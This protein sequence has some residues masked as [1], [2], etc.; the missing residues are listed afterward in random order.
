MLAAVAAVRVG[1]LQGAPSRFRPRLAQE[2]VLKPGDVVIKQGDQ[3]DAW[4]IVETGT[5]DI[6]VNGAKLASRGPGDAFG[7]LALLYNCPRA[8]TVVATTAAR[9]WA[10]DRVTFRYM[11]AS[12]REGQL[13][14]IVRGLRG[15]E[16]LKSL[17]DEQLNRVAEAVKVGGGVA[18][19]DSGGRVTRM[20]VRYP[21]PPRANSARRLCHTARAS[22]SSRRA[23]SARRST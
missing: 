19:M 21:A 11:I 2:R 9:V 5:F 3:G 13:A 6:I 10:L 18:C 17:S 16:L 7:E 22:A 20:N 12:T 4:Y 1:W 8:A 23:S 14:E 15:L